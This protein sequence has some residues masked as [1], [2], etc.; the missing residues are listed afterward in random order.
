MSRSVETVSEREQDERE[1]DSV[2]D[3]L[4]CDT[5]RIGSF[6]AQFD[7]A[8]HL[9]QVIQRESVVKGVK[10][11]VEIGVGGGATLAGTGGSGNL[12]F[13]R[14]PSDEGSEGSERLY[15]P[16]WTNARA[17]LD[18]LAEKNIIERDLT[19]AHMGQF[20]L[21]SGAL[22][23]R[24]LK[25]I[26]KALT[27]IKG[28][29]LQQE[30]PKNQDTR[31][32]SKNWHEKHQ[33][34]QKLGQEAAAS[35]AGIEF[36]ALL[37]HAVHAVLKMDCSSVW[38][39]LQPESLVGSSD[40]IFLK[41]GVGIPGEWH[42]LGIL[43]ALPDVQA[44]KDPTEQFANAQKAMSEVGDNAAITLAT[45]GF[46]AFI[47]G[48]APFARMLLGRQ[49]GSYGMTPLLIFRKVAS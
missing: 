38:C 34:E 15:D 30:P 11:G 18:Y 28:V 22:E 29:R 14:G 13:K 24:D 42:I 6:L 2:F 26:Q 44:T 10:R 1:N 33:P 27:V 25:L 45:K 48:I 40:D 12:S 31:H 5:R 43:D 36:L 4:Y 17:F 9:Q 37:P 41:H 46:G 47:D 35:Q 49:S 23:I 21:V 3:F 20:V 19:K 32:R 8:G 39:S 16:L 7:D